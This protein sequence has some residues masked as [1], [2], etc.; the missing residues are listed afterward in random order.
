M[1]DHQSSRS[2]IVLIFARQ[3]FKRQ[4]EKKEGAK[5]PRM[6]RR[7][8]EVAQGRFPLRSLRLR[9][10]T[11]SQK[12]ACILGGAWPFIASITEN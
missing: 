12:L 2:A 6:M 11:R 8:F 7:I 9:A 3:D 4:I 1:G 5:N 10:S